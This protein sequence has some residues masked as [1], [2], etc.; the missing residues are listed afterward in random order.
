M[1]RR[2]L[3]AAAAAPFAMAAKPRLMSALCAYSYRD[4]LAKK[5]LSYFDLVE[6]CADN[7][8]PGLDATV[9]WFP[10]TE[11]SFLL[12]LKKRAYRAGV[13][14]YSI[15]VRTE[16]TKDDPAELDKL[17][18]WID[19]AERLG[20]NHIRVFGGAV[21]KGLTEDDAAARVV[22]KLKQAGEHSGKRGVYLGLENHGG[23]TAKAERIVQMVKAVDHPWV[24]I[25]LDF[26]NFRENAYEQ[27]ELCVPHAVAVQ[28]KVLTEGK[29]SD[30][31][32]LA[33]ALVKGGYRG[34]LA[35]EY[36]EKEPAETAVPRLFGD[37]KK[38]I[39]AAL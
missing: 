21:P 6:I 15:S 23:I 32:R 17:K 19:V 26:G 1:L 38:A 9:Y 14:L 11:D 10:S 30:W 18:K 2:T 12:D 28:V 22:E 29:P 31:P 5:R 34:Y 27:F 36:E 13:D 20:A 24:G 4:A 25:N 8:V 3:L 16:L 35:L 37:L 7:D 39:Q 33:K